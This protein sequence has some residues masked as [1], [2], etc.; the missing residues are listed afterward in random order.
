MTAVPKRS[1]SRSREHRELP[2]SPETA[3]QPKIAAVA[4]ATSMYSVTFTDYTDDY[5]C[6]D[7]N[8]SDTSTSR[9]VATMEEARSLVCREIAN[10]IRDNKIEKAFCSVVRAGGAKML[11]D[12]NW[13]R[14][15]AR[16]EGWFEWEYCPCTFEW[17][18]AEVQLESVDPND[19]WER[20]YWEEGEMDEWIQ[21]LKKEARRKRRQ[22]RAEAKEAAEKKAKRKLKRQLDAKKIRTL[23]GETKQIVDY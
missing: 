18:F 3:T 13:L 9:L 2:V 5:K 4:T 16:D 15:T 10:R 20:T 12:Y 19:G 23:Q 1:R 14:K 8:W 17:T 7:D 21:T 11:H 6:R 22:E